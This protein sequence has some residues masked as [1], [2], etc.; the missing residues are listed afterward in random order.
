MPAT[1]SD[2][3]DSSP[4]GDSEVVEET[5]VV[6]AADAADVVLVMPAAEQLAC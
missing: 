5:I 4:Q 1:F 6:V 3:R 2:C